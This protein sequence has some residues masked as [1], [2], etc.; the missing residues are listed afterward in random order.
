MQDT[1]LRWMLV[2]LASLLVLI[3][4]LFLYPQASN[5]TAAPHPTHA[6]LLKSQGPYPP[7]AS[8]VG[9]VFG[10]LLIAMMVLTM[11]VGLFR[12]GKPSRLTTWI[13]RFFAVYALVW[14]GIKFVDDAYVSGSAMP[15]FGGFPLPTAMLVYGMGIIA[16]VLIPFYYRF[17]TSDVHSDADQQRFEA[18][19]AENKKAGGEV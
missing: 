11:I 1:H 10:L 14:V 9:V 19:L 16:L 8:W 6:S 13:L 5:P 18:L 3:G 15:F 7:F 2:V 17:F 12:E 4:F